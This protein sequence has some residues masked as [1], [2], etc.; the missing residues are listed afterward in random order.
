MEHGGEGEATAIL[1][2][3]EGGSEGSRRIRMLL[4]VALRGLLM[5]LM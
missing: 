1:Q 5:D 2:R 4:E 3:D